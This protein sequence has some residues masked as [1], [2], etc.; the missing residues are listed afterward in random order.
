MKKTSFIL[1]FIVSCFDAKAQSI[2]LQQCYELAEQHYPLAKQKNLIAQTKAYSIEN[3]QKGYLPQIS[4]LGQA[5]YQSDV[6]GIPFSFPGMDIPKLSKDQYKVYGEINQTLYD[7]GMI[8]NQKKLHEA[9]AIVEEQNVT[10]ELYRL[11]ERINQLYFGIL[12]I[13]KQLLLTELRKNDIQS[14][15]DRTNGAIANGI[16]FKSNADVLKAELLLA[17]QAATEQKA[18]QKAYLDMLSLFIG[19]SLNSNTILA[20]PPVPDQNGTPMRPELAGFDYRKRLIDINEYMLTAKNQPKISLF[21][22]GGYGKPGL[23]FLKNE[24]VFYGV[25]GIRFS[26]LL[27]GF[28]TNKSDRL[29]LENNRRS[30]DIQ[31][32]S[33]LFNNNISA[34]QDQSEIAKLKELI[35]TD[36]AIIGLRTNVKNASN[37][38]LENGVKMPADYVRDVNLESQSRQNLALHQVQLLYAQYRLKTTLGN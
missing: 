3:A 13:N 38:Q 21:V 24:F 4:I 7:G 22:Q 34:T 26:W 33:F 15:L 28:Y 17:D 19:Q 30:L 5:T 11:R 18:L 16:A 31:K 14:G 10:V 25:G 35:G 1:L 36:D 32:E 27:T 37:A 9:N 8:R 2:T 20:E 6:T 29:I 23:N 12:L